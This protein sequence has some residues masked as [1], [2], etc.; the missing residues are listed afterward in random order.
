MWWPSPQLLWT[1]LFNFLTS[2]YFFTHFFIYYASHRKNMFQVSKR[3]FEHK[4]HGYFSIVTK[5]TSH[6]FFCHN[7]HITNFNHNKINL[8]WY[9]IL[10]FNWKEYRVIHILS[11]SGKY[12]LQVK[13][14]YIYHMQ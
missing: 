1:F 9:F 7:K 11:L 4:W 2:L 5:S 12:N 14:I 6:Q 10:F 3:L 8:W 13:I